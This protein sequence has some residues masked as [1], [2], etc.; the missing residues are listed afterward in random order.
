MTLLHADA[1]FA[2]AV[3]GWLVAVAAVAQAAWTVRRSFLPTAPAQHA[4]LAAIVTVSLLWALHVRSPVGL[5]FGLLGSACVALVF[6][7]ARAVLG[8]M[9]ALVLYTA[10]DAGS[11]FNIG[12]NGVVLALVPA[13]LATA[14]QRQIEQRLPK[15]LF[16]FII[17]NGLFVTLAATVCASALGD[18]LAYSLLLAWGEALISGMLFSALVVFTPQCVLTYRQDLYLPPRRPLT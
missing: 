15:N 6:G 8:L 7:R 13:W 11:W 9:A 17:G 10:L 5:D 4:W 18:H 2:L 1:P 12:I 3:F 14:L 16:V